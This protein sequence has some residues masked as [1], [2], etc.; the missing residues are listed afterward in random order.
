MA[1]I[2]IEI[3]ARHV[4]LNHADLEKLFGSGY[5]LK[6]LRE[7]SQ[8]GQFASR[9]RVIVKTK[10]GEFPTVRV[11]GPMRRNTQVEISMTDARKLGIEPPVKRSG[12]LE[13][14]VGAFLIGPRGKVKLKNGIIIAKRHIHCSDKEAKKY[15]VKDGEEVS[16]KVDGERS[17]TFHKVV[18]RIRKDFSWSM[19]VDADE[20]NAAGVTQGAVGEVIR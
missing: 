13:G 11:L 7:L 20:G 4:H 3:S 9:E 12:N 10:K 8:K 17:L 2:K 16:V 14:S 18:V 19:H 6:I 1:R 15:K 5:N